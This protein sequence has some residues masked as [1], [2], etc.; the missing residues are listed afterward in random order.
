MNEAGAEVATDFIDKLEAALTKISKQPG[1][2][3]VRYGHEIQV[4]GLRSWQMDRFPYLIFYLETGNRIEILRVLHSHV[5]IPSW[6]HDSD[7]KG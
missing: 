5:D 3:S 1:I 7:Q 4:E 6:L 2:G